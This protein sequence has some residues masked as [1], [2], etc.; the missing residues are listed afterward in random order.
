[1]FLISKTYW[2]GP[3][4]EFRRAPEQATL[5]SLSL[6]AADGR[7]FRAL[8]WKPANHPK[9]RIAIVAMHPRVDFTH[10]YSFPRLLAAGY[11]CFGANTR[12]PNNDIDTVHEEIVLDLAEC[13][14]FLRASGVERVILLGNSGGGSL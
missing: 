12:N 2:S 3:P 4:F 1:M 5:E 11:G 6:R 9:P 14:R 13:I 8:W 7:S 10:H